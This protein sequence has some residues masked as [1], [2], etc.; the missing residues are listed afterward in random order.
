[1]S[2]ELTYDGPTPHRTSQ[3]Q[4]GRQNAAQASSEILDRVPPEAMDSEQV[5]LASILLDPTAADMAFERLGRE[6]FYDDANGTIFQAMRDLASE[7]RGQINLES[8]VAHMRD[9][10]QWQKIGGARYIGKIVE[11]G[12]SASYSEYHIRRIHSASSKR[13]LIQECM[14]AIRN[15]YESGGQ[16]HNDL[17][18]DVASGLFGVLER[19][20]ESRDQT[21]P[22][23]YILAEAVERMGSETRFDDNTITTGYE[24]I[25]RMCGGFRRQEMTIIGARPG[26]GKTSLGLRMVDKA[27]ES[28][29]SVLMFSLEMNSEELAMRMLSQRTGVSSYRMRNQFLGVNERQRI[30]EEAGS[31]HGRDLHI[32]DLPRMTVTQMAAVARRQVRRARQRNPNA[33]GVDL[34]VIDY[35]QLIDTENPRDPRHEQ[36]GKITR[37]LRILARELDCA[38]VVLAQVNRQSGD[39]NRLPK[40]SELRESG[41]IEQDADVVMFI[42]REHAENFDKLR[43]LRDAREAEPAVLAI[44]KQR[45]GPTGQIKMFFQQEQT[46]FVEA[47]TRHPDDQGNLG[48]DF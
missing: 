24:A 35:L 4:N 10:D 30:V 1:M 9:H 13:A 25:D 14:E 11:R 21:R 46:L 44:A 47:D 12:G 43:E 32:D 40:L 27:S 5:L 6:D 26:N 33:S 8:L 15:C 28:G 29:A 23:S 31:L 22:L 36:V 42:H 48:D 16:D 45:S 7:N 18:D 41:S 2:R 17:L 38:L 39:A 19:G 20:M 37:R 3:R 34:I